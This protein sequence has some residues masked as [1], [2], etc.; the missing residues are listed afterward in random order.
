MILHSPWALYF[1][2]RTPMAVVITELGWEL[3][4]E[5]EASRAETSA[6]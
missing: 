3:A 4:A 6:A 1:C 5:L 2:E